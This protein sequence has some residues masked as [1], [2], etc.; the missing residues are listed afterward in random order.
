MSKSNRKQKGFTLV[1]LLVTIAILAIL[2]G[3]CVVS[4]TSFIERAAISND[5]AMV[6]QLN[7]FLFAYSI[8]NGTVDDERELNNMLYYTELGSITIHSA[9]YNYQIYFNLYGQS[10]ELLKEGD[11]REGITYFDIPEDFSTFISD[12]SS[13]IPI[14]EPDYEPKPEPESNFTINDSFNLT[15]DKFNA[16]VENE[17]LFV[18]LWIEDGKLKKSIEINL[19]EIVSASSDQHLSLDISYSYAGSTLTTYEHYSPVKPYELNSTN[20]TIIFYTPGEYIINCSTENSEKRLTVYVENTA[21]KQSQFINSKSEHSPICT[22]DDS[23]LTIMLPI[24]DHIMIQDYSFDSLIAGS[25]IK[26]KDIC[27]NRKNITIKINGIVVEYKVISN[28]TYQ[29]AHITNID[30]L[31]VIEYEI[32]YSYLGNNG[33]WI[34]ISE[35]GSIIQ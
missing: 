16:Y 31:D 35:T 29:L 33:L 15:Q 28:I 22:S 34:E 17:I 10:F 20:E 2:A 6:A 23:S 13:N 1:E 8:E 19:N 7:D 14:P 9:Q 12:D 26:W 3:V 18:Q 21:I 25:T 4:Y 24:V 32:I 27:E 30:I 11:K 5:E